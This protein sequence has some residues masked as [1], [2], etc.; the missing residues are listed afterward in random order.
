MTLTLSTG[1]V[2]LLETNP[3]IPPEIKVIIGELDPTIKGES[4]LAF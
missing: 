2:M 1:A 4:S 3:A